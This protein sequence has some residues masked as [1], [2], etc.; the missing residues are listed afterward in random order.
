MRSTGILGG[1]GAMVGAV[2]VIAVVGVLAVALAIFVLPPATITVSPPLE[3]VGPVSRTLTADSTAIEVDATNGIIPAEGVKIPG[4][5]AGRLHRHRRQD[6]RDEGQGYGDVLELRHQWQ[7]HRSRRAASWPPTRTCASAPWHPPRLAKAKVIGGTTIVP[8]TDSVR[9]EAVK[10]GTAGNVPAN[11]IHNV[12]GGQD[13]ILLKVTNGAAT[14]GSEKSKSA[15][16]S[17]ED[18][19]LAARR[20]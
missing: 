8:G 14:K 9:V 15:R 6:H 4:V 3:T 18:V 12:P 20:S 13:P 5:G 11:A 2:A 19:D 1:R 16:V 7:T 17:Q 10:A